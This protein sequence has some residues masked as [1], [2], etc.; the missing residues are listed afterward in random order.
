MSSRTSARAEALSRTLPRTQSQTPGDWLALTK[1]GIVVSNVLMAAVGLALAPGAGWP[2]ILATLVGT[3][4]LVASCG[5][6]NM[7]LEAGPDA[8]MTRTNGRPVASGRITVMAAT[9]FGVVLM[10][11]GLTM[12][13]HFT[14]MEVA[15]L[16]GLACF[17]YLG[18]YTPLKRVSWAAIPVG[19]VAG[20]IP[21]V[22]GWFAGGGGYDLVALLLFAALFV[23]QIPHFLAIGLR[24][25]RDYREAG[26]RIGADPADF[27]SPI[28]LIR[29]SSVILTVVTGATALFA[30][31]GYGFMAFGLAASLFM[32]AASLRPV[33]DA[34]RWSRRVFLAS[35]AYLPAFALGAF[36]PV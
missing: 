5:A 12:L 18:L 36:L 11:S 13:A 2:V 16:G 3:A 24:R 27:Y 32:V 20:A 30:N 25:W 33:D 21:P 10:S 34:V 23:W 31:V 4:L 26:L 1:P 14:N 29:G 8:K 17:F 19:A 22:M 15:G 7:V 9:L 28:L 6:L 35:L